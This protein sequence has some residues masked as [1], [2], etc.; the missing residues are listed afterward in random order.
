MSVRVFK[1]KTTRENVAL[2]LF[3]DL[4]EGVVKKPRPKPFETIQSASLRH[5][6]EITEKFNALFDPDSPIQCFSWHRNCLASYVSEEKIRKREICLYKK[7]VQ[8]PVQDTSSV[9]A[10]EKRQSQRVKLPNLQSVCVICVKTT[11]KKDKKLYQLSELSAAEN[12]FATS[13]LKEDEVFTRISTADNPKDLFAQ[14][15]KYHKTCYLDYVR[16]P[17]TA[18]KNPGRPSSKI[19][20]EVLESAFNTLISEIDFKTTCF[21]LSYL[22]HKMSLLTG[23]DDVVVGNRILKLIDKYG[24]RVLFSHPADRSKSS[25]VLMCDVPLTE[26][27]ERIRELDSAE[28]TLRKCAKILREEVQVT[29]LL[30][31]NYL[32]DVNAVDTALKNMTLPPNWNIFFQAL[33]SA[34]CT[35]ELKDSKLRRAKSFFCD[36]FHVITDKLTPKHISCFYLV[37]PIKNFKYR[38]GVFKSAMIRTLLLVR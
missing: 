36:I 10:D 13:R 31:E 11:R 27:V 37:P 16:K 35:T 26:A 24:E 19:P 9:S 34:K 6:D 17:R 15:I 12:L 38:K 32:I 33:L 25:L 20:E 18:S 23:L 28:S 2:C 5:K 7:E 8:E 1:H 4:R 22:S 14:E 30:D 3:C 29:E 21:E